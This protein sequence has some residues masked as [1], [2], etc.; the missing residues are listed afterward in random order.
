MNSE[1]SSSL[2]ENRSLQAGLVVSTEVIVPVDQAKNPQ[3]MTIT[4]HATARSLSVVAEMSP[5]PIVVIVV[6]AQ[7]RAWWNKK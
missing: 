6:I 4:T 1:S 2:S 7:Y 3:P 5:Y